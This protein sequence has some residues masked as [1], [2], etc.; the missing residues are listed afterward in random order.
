MYSVSQKKSPPEVFWHF[1]PKR[2]RI[3]NQFFA[4]LLHVPIYARLQIFIQVFVVCWL[5]SMNGQNIL[6][7][8]HCKG[9][10]AT[11]LT[12]SQPTRLPCVGSRAMLQAFHKLQSKP[13]TTPELKCTAADLGWLATDND[14]QSYQINNFHKRLNACVSAD[15]G[16]Y[17]HHDVN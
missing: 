16:H 9:P 11:K 7:R 10:M 13:K 6:R 8:L 2:L 5:I 14:Q 15:D 4:Y 17:E 1:F 12:R 3:F